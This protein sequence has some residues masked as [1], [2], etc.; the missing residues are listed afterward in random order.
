MTRRAWPAAGLI[1]AAMLA[2][3]LLVAAEA[4]AQ[5]AFEVMPTAE[6]PHGYDSWSI[7]LICNPAWLDR[8]GDEGIAR[9]FAQYQHF[10]EAIGP[11][12]LAIW[13]WKEPALEPSADL[14][15]VSRSSVYCERYELLPS[16]APYVLVTTAHPDAEAP[17]DRFVIS[18][19]GLGADETAEMLARLT[20]QLLVTGLDQSGLN[21]SRDWQRLLGAA[22][23]LFEDLGSYFTDVAFTIDTGFFR[24]E[25]RH[26]AP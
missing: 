26:A 25:L 17:G 19:G 15:D 23:S 3:S 6:I 18:L 7:F 5:A 16:R 11:D 14:T 10:G 24:A 13:F 9:L 8:N 20:D 21:A 4:R 22:A 1:F 12:N 2:P